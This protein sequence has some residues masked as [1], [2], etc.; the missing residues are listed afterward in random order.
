VLAHLDDER[1]VVHS[2]KSH[3]GAR[4][5]RVEFVAEFRGGDPVA[6]T[7][8]MVDTLSDLEAG[9]GWSTD[10]RGSTHE[11]DGGAVVLSG[12]NVFLAVPGAKAWPTVESGTQPEVRIRST[13]AKGV[14][15]VAISSDRED[16]EGGLV[17]REYRV[18]TMRNVDPAAARDFLDELERDGGAAITEVALDRKDV[19]WAVSLELATAPVRRPGR[20]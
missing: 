4:G 11:I 18:R 3:S 15:A 14:G 7:Q 19:N 12:A 9:T 10:G 6:S 1:I 17:L 8:L 2:L 5:A 13:A 16:L 20:G